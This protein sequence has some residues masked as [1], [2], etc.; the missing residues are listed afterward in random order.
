ME[1]SNIDA[2][3]RQLPFAGKAAK[4]SSQLS[5]KEG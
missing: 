5:G 1:L 2:L 3:N 4:G